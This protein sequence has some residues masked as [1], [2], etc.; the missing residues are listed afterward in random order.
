L[1]ALRDWKEKRVKVIGY[2]N[3]E[4]LLF[5]FVLFKIWLLMIE[6]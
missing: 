4:F 1:V 3:F 2:L 5:V 6:N